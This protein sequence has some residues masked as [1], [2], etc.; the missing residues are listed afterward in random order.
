MAILLGLGA[1]VAG[2]WGAPPQTLARAVGELSKAGFALVQCSSL[3]STAPVGPGRQT[4]YLNAVIQV[5]GG[6]KS[7]CA[8]LR[9]AKRL[10]W[11]AGRRA[12]RHWGPRPLD[13]DIL[14]CGR[15]VTA[16]SRA[17]RRIGRLILPHPEMHRRAFVLQPLLEIAPTWR[18]PRFGVGA[19]RLLA[20]LPTRERAQV[21]PV[22]DSAG[23]ACEKPRK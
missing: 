3:Y 22:L 10:E 4:R 6:K 18:H 21:V 23:W 11:Q 1:N 15:S 5:R 2:R 16:P 20:R 14:A 8:L 17:P 13:I 9:I 12:G 19:G 7:L